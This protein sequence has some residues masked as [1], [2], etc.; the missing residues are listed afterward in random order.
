MVNSTMPIR[1]EVWSDFVCPFCFA[2][3]Y[4]LKELAELH[5]VAIHWRSFELR[6]KESPP[7]SP[8]YLA[9]IEASRPR[10]V[11]MMWEMYGVDI[12]PGSFGINSRPALIA[13]K[14]A[15]ALD[16]KIGAAFHDAVFRA[17]WM[18]G[19]NIEDTNVLRAIAAQVGLDGDELL[20]AIDNPQYETAVNAEMRQAYAYGLRGVPALIFEEKYLVSGWQTSEVLAQVIDEMKVLSR[21]SAE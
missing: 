17:Y 11:Q 2:A 8:E 15:E 6:P 14:Y 4:S 3:S 21:E 1:I 9:R 13:A 10:F 18:E 7:I 12:Q 20:A 19:L 5:D 16:E